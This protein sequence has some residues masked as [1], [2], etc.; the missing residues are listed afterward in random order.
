MFHL[1]NLT[2]EGGDGSRFKDHVFAQVQAYFS[3]EAQLPR[4]AKHFI[5]CIC[6]MYSCW[7]NVT[8]RMN[9]NVKCLTKFHTIHI[10]SLNIT[11]NKAR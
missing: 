11:A 2:G 9:F 6:L 4:D 10:W 5:D 7:Q 8:E 1:D 3:G